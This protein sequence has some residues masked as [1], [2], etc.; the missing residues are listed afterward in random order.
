MKEMRRKDR[1]I[2]EEEAMAVL[3]AAEFGVLSTVS[4]GGE[5]YGVPLNYCVVGRS[6]YFH[7]APEGQKIDNISTNSLVSFC[8]VGRTEV[9]SEQFTTNYESVIVTGEAEEV[10]DQ[11]KQLALEGLLRKYSPSF[12]EKGN[13]YRVAMEPKSRVFKIAISR[14]SGKARKG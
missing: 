8:A 13:K 3:N 5:P 9:L 1:A 7:C 4:R 12:L 11:E 14:I 2:P 10:F 6:L